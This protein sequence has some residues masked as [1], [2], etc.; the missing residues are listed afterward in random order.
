MVL[1]YGIG[2]VALNLAL[3]RWSFEAS[4]HR[5][6]AVIFPTSAYLASGFVVGYMAKRAPLMHGVL[7]G[8][9]IMALFGGVTFVV[10]G[11]LDWVA[12]FQ[13]AAGS[14]VVCAL[15]AIAG[16]LIARR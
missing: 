15:G 16:S 10:A 6:I 2:S 11:Q 12:F 14:M 8:L 4:Q 5:I 1:V 3:P 13:L 9:L 7:L